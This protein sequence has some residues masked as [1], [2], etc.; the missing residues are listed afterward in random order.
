[1]PWKTQLSSGCMVLI[2]DGWSGE[3]FGE[4]DL[5]STTRLFEPLLKASGLLWDS[6]SQKCECGD[7]I[8]NS[9]GYTLRGIFS[10]TT[11]ISSVT[12]NWYQPSQLESKR[13]PP[14]LFKRCIDPKTPTFRGQ[15]HS[16]SLIESEKCH[17]PISICVAA[18]SWAA[19]A[20]RQATITNLIIFL[21]GHCVNSTDQPFA[22]SAPT[23]DPAIRTI[24][25][26][27]QN[28]CSI[29]KNIILFSIG[30]FI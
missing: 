11:F 22:C 12:C 6:T 5:V 29:N 4:F 21:M 3:T 7:V 17:Q 8:W 28:P 9:D 26:T 27:V 19:H 23:P 18:F 16:L 13:A 30:N 15:V 24:G 10:N 20:L 2:S 25:R 14:L 1:M